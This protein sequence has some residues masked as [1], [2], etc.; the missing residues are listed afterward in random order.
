MRLGALS[1]NETIELLAHALRAGIRRFHS[2]SEYESFS[3]FCESLPKAC[4]LANVDTDSLEHM[5]KIAAPHFDHSKFV[6]QELISKTQDYKRKLGCSKIELIQWMAR[7]D[8]SNEAGRLAILKDSDKA[9]QETVELLKFNND[10]SRFGCF[11]YTESFRKMATGA[12][13]CDA[14]I[15]YFNPIEH[16]ASQIIDNLRTNQSM[17]AIRPL[18]PL[19]KKLE[20]PNNSE[21]AM[22][23]YDN[24][25]RYALAKPSVESLVISMSSQKHLDELIT[26]I[27]SVDRVE[28]KS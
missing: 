13:W 26:S 22:W 25:I 20:E 8:L 4:K 11:P 27:Q 16:Q 6:P 23:N 12:E 9:I 1:S 18:F 21:Y 28:S 14:L 17:I 10:I 7:Y 3:L 15:D 24:L 5:V 19:I 2:S